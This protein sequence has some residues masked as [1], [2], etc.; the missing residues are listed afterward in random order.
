MKKNV[1]WRSDGFEELVYLLDP[2]DF[3]TTHTQIIIVITNATIV[4]IGLSNDF[5]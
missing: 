4:V 1:N 3:F 5:H 2:K